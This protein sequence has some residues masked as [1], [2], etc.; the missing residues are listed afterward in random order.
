[1]E[2]KD[3]RPFQDQDQLYQTIDGK[4]NFATM[5]ELLNLPLQHLDT[6]THG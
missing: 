6:A 5:S 4:D 3:S 1:M 2:F